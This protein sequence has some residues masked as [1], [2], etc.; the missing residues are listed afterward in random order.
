MHL[1]F[2]LPPEI[3]EIVLDHMDRRSLLNTQHVCRHWR[4]EVLNYA[5]NGRLKNRAF[6]G[7]IL[8]AAA[9]SLTSPF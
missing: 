6:V 9:S 3:W 8:A 2:S 4:N 5:M 7:L 1:S